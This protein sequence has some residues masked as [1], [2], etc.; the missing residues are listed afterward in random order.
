VRHYLN[1]DPDG[2]AYIAYSR[3]VGIGHQGGEK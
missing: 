2:Q 1:Y 3:L